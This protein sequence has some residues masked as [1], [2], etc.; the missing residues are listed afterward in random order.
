M[1]ILLGIRHV[2]AQDSVV[3]E[4]SG[5]ELEQTMRLFQLQNEFYESP[6]LKPHQHTFSYSQIFGQYNDQQNDLYIYQLGNGQKSWQILSES[7]QKPGKDQALWGKAYYA[8]KKLLG[9][10]YNESL[11][12]EI[13]YPYVMADTI[14]GDL[15]SETYFFE[16]GYANRW[17]TLTYGFSGGFRG[18]QAYRDHDPRPKNTVSDLYLKMSVG[19]MLSPIY[20]ISV[21]LTGGLYKQRNQ[22]TF[23]NE[24]GAPYISQEAGFGVYNNLISGSNNTAYINGQRIRSQL[25]IVPVTKNGLAMQLAIE[26][27]SFHKQLSSIVDNIADANEKKLYA[28]IGYLRQS[29]QNHS[30]IQFVFEHNRREGVEA[31]FSNS[32]NS[33]S[34]TKIAEDLR[35]LNRGLIACLNAGYGTLHPH[36]AWTISANVAY[37]QNEATYA[38]PNR[39]IDVSNVSAS[40]EIGGLHHYHKTTV[41]AVLSIQKNSNLSE[42]YQWEQVKTGSGVE[43]MLQSTYTYLSAN[44]WKLEASFGAFHPLTYKLKGFIKLAGDYTRYAH[45]FNGHQLILSAGCIF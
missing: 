23:V 15:Q 37:K 27:F 43:K 13:I 6:A 3:Y 36:T 21:D 25:N 38:D 18:V 14:G 9:I 22:L 11:D 41:N 12:Y 8:N 40:L 4:P 20:E 29:D 24:L 33:T 44:Y 26:D 5:L 39:R 7:Y 16:G 1:L 17:K 34:I 28:A 42:Q 30:L 45:P 2:Y 32:G 31:K 10:N 19:K 35:F